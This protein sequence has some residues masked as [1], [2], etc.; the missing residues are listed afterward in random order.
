MGKIDPNLGGTD[1]PV[2]DISPAGGFYVP[3]YTPPAGGE[4]FPAVVWTNYPTLTPGATFTG[5]FGVRLLDT[6]PLPGIGSY[7]NTVWLDSIYTDP[8]SS[9]LK[10]SW[11]VDETPYGIFAKGDNLDSYF[12]ITAGEDDRELF[13]KPGAS[14]PYGLA[15][16]NS[17]MVALNDLIFVDMVP[18]GTT[19]KSAWFTDPWLQTNAVIFY[20]TVD[21]G[22]VS[23]PPAYGPANAPADIDIDG[24][25]LWSI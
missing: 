8:I 12:G 9:S 4:P 25:D 23:A 1:I 11:P 22:D 15:V 10:V 13:V 7:I 2:V 21:T 14:F 24:G 3:A 20:S 17:G 18:A 16:H 5:S 19:F 6:P